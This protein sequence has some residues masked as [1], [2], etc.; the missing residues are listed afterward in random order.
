M[1]V[2]SPTDS[3]L[4]QSVKGTIVNLLVDSYYNRKVDQWIMISNVAAN[5]ADHYLIRDVVLNRIRDLGLTADE[6]DV[7]VSYISGTVSL[8]FGRCLASG[9]FRGSAGMIRDVKDQVFY[10]MFN[11][12]A[13][14]VLGLCKK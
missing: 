9:D 12:A 3:K 4:Y 14:V 7:V 2:I 5:F 1:S 11:A 6:C 8:Y 10:T 13:N